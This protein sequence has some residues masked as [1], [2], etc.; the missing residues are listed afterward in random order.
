MTW[1]ARHNTAQSLTL[2]LTLAL[3]ASGPAHAL[4]RDRQQEVLS[5]VG[6]VFFAVTVSQ[7]IAS[8][9]GAMDWL[10]E[11]ALTERDAIFPELEAE[12]FSEEEMRWPLQDDRAL[13]YAR[14][15]MAEYTAERAFEPATADEAGWCALGQEEMET[16]SRIGSYLEAK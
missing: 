1:G 15:Q 3:A 6:G 16:R 12:G 9:C 2:A 7:M 8:H 13:N 4:D 14:A 5:R 11:K 10:G